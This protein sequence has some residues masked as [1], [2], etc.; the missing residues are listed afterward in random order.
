MAQINYFT[1]SGTNA[2]HGDVY[3][4][5]NGSLFN[6]ENYFLHANDTTDNTPKSPVP[7]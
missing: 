4:I 5:W 1:K 3:E 7:P 2:F 6:A